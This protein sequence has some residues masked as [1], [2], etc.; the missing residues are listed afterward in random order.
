MLRESPNCWSLPWTRSTCF[1]MSS[2]WNWRTRENVSTSS[3]IAH[4][5]LTEMIPSGK[6]T[7]YKL[8]APTPTPSTPSL[9]PTPSTTSTLPFFLPSVGVPKWSESSSFAPR[10]GLSGSGEVYWK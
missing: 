1:E 3:R 6:T 7:R 9:P 4:E 8:I 2:K 5:E 10:L